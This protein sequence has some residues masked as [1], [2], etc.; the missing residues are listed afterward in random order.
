MYYFNSRD[1]F[2]KKPFGAVKQGCQ[3]SFKVYGNGES[4][5]PVLCIKKDGGEENYFPLS[6]F[7][8]Q[9]S[10]AY[11]EVNYT[12]RQVGLYFYKFILPN[13][14]YSIFNDGKGQ[15]LFAKE[16]VWFT[17]TVYEKDF[18]T[19]N[20]FKDGVFYQIFPDRFY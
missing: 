6:S 16:G 10:D 19:P 12:F 20:R 5:P 8:D 2:F 9:N 7:R 1:E 14:D 15:S 3:I 11:F 4:T 18:T 13:S 17:Q